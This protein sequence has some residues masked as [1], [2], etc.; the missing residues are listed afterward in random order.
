[1]QTMQHR[2]PDSDGLWHN[3]ENYITGFVRLAIRDTSSFGDQPMISSCKNYAIT[4]NGEIYN[5]DLFKPT[6]EKYGVRFS[7]TSDTEILLY[8][9]IH[10]G[11]KQ[12]L[13]E[14]D[15]IFAFAFYNKQKDELL[16]ARDRLG[17]KPLYI[18]FDNNDAVIFSSQ[19]DHIINYES[20]KNQPI[21]TAAIG[22]Y[23]QVGFVPDNGGAIK[24]TILFPHG[25]YAVVNKSGYRQIPYYSSM[26]AFGENAKASILGENSF[27]KA[28]W[29][30]L[31]SDV[32]VGTYL[33]GGV[34]SSLISSWAAEKQ[35]ITAYTIGTND[36]FTDEK[37]YASFIA[38]KLHIPHK[39]QDI[40]EK[41]LFAVL[42]DNTKAYSE[43]FADFSSIPSLVLSKFAAKNVKVILSGDGPDELFWGYER[44]NKFQ[45][46]GA[47]FFKPGH[48][49]LSLLL[50]SKIS[51]K[52][53]FVNKRMFATKDF[54][55]FYYRSLFLYGSSW[56]KDVY[57]HDSS[58]AFFLN[59]IRKHYA[60]HSTQANY[61]NIVRDIEMNIH[62]QRILLKVDRAGMYNSLEVRVPFLANDIL[63]AA[64]SNPCHQQHIKN[65]EGK[66][67][68]KT[69]LA[70]KVGNDA[71]FR[72]KKGFLIPMSSWLR[73]SIKK[74]VEEKLMNMPAELADLF[75]KK[76]VEKLWHAQTVLMEGHDGIIW[77]IYSLINWYSY[78]RASKKL[79]T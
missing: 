38:E 34:D 73:Q 28:V 62:L 25:Y 1:M 27:Q 32:P 19:Y 21:N 39:I 44:N 51:G 79:A 40:S 43:P 15:G 45:K 7:S 41:D 11:I 68:L 35:N 64:F 65:G 2:G 70:G 24:N 74:D 67:Q 42:E 36:A 12:V 72:H 46:N 14:F 69:M 52:K 22:S 4:F 37:Q 50:G 6:L 9:L 58:E 76:Q 49:K 29:Q 33:S 75:N 16:L 5:A 77:A 31:V 53:T 17:I 56:V 55:S 20:L 59:E 60:G 26:S 8:S 57:K 61:M 78:H 18:G 13:E 47:I 10:L 66:F 63:K 30:Q 23:L 48:K 71:T 3:G 54:F